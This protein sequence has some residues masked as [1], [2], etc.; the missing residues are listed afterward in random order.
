M[1]VKKEDKNM[2]IIINIMKRLLGVK[3]MK[4][5]ICVILLIFEVEEKKIMER[6]H[7]SYNTVKKYSVLLK[8]DRLQDLFEDK[9]YRPQSEMENYRAEIIEALEKNPARTLREA[10]IIIEQVTGIKRS[11]PQVR[12]FLKKNGYKPLK[13]GIMP[14]KADPQIQC[15]F[16]RKVL[17]PLIAEA[18]KG[19]VQLFF[20]DASHFVQGG[21][22]GQLWC[23]ARIFVKA[24][25]GRSRYNVLGALNFASKKM[26]TI[27]ND[28][29]ITS[30]QVIMLIDK[31]IAQ[32]PG[33]AIKLV[34]DNASYQRCK[35]VTNYAKSVGVELI[36][37]PSYS[38]NLN[39]IER[40]WKF[41]KAEV[42]NAAYISTFDEFKAIIDDCL[43]KLDTV[44]LDK[45]Q[46]LTTG[47]FQ[48][49]DMPIWETKTLIMTK[50]KRQTK[51]NPSILAA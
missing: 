15:I 18:K 46:T 30:T 35:L 28:A 16:V 49:F 42:L 5:I 44:Y 25:S 7:V 43:S 10:A 12:N 4:Q 48:M 26:T 20:V 14:A 1:Q 9:Q 23:K 2:Q 36:F 8:E 3:L 34:M 6:L 51:Q 33:K 29:Y 31:L 13:T 40:V 41:V 19:K 27:T 24:A 38:P 50:A 37:L 32:Y 39:L 45:M 11:L 22:I 47:K 17:N 21:F